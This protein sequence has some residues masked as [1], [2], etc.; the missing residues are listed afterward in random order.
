MKKIDFTEI[1][2]ELNISLYEQHYETEVGFEY[3]TNGFMSSISIGGFNIWNSEDDDRE[4]IEEENDY[5]PFLP[6]IKNKFNELTDKLISLKFK[7]E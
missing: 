4:W 7:N 2:R 6:F 1:V 5:E 3:C